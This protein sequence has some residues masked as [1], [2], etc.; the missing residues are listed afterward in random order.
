[1]SQSIEFRRRASNSYGQF[2][3]GGSTFPGFLYK[4]SNCGGQRRSTRLIPGVGNQPGSIW[5]T[6]TPGSGVGATSIAN[7]R[8]KRFRASTIC[9]EPNEFY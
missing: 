9:L 3:Y 8:A 6:Y 4:K 5:N 7:R 2:W 1:M